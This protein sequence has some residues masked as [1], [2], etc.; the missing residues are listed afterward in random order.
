MS[1]CFSF[2]RV[3]VNGDWFKILFGISYQ[4]YF[5]GFVWLAT[6]TIGE[7]IDEDQR[8]SKYRFLPLSAFLW[9]DLEICSF[10][11][12]CSTK[13]DMNDWIKPSLLFFFFR[14]HFCSI[15]FLVIG[16]VSQAKYFFSFYSSLGIYLFLLLLC[17]FYFFSLLFSLCFR[18]FTLFVFFCLF[19]SRFIFLV[20]SSH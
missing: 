7:I 12:T 3:P 15:L 20:L 8:Q 13:F 18:L 9:N 5:A 19:L 17:Y 2:K 4:I 6:R 11:T 10:N 14:F 1:L 16:Y